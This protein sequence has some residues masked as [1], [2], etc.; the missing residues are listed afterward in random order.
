M[1]QQYG[2][3]EVLLCKDRNGSGCRDNTQSSDCPAQR[4]GVWYDLATKC[5]ALEKETGGAS[6]AKA[7]VN[8]LDCGG[9]DLHC[10]KM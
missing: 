10:W 7:R 1:S 9:G 6:G 8:G 5:E 3:E 2:R 4:E